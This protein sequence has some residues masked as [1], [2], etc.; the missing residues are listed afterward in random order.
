MTVVRTRKIAVAA[1]ALANGG[2]LISFESESGDFLIDSPWPWPELVQRFMGSQER[3]FDDH[4]LRLRELKR[5][6]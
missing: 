4:V 3:R 6:A 1:Y 2:T 5:G